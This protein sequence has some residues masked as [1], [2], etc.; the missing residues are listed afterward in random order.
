MYSLFSVPSVAPQNVTVRVNE[1]ML[2]VRWEAP[3]PDK[4]NGILQGYD[5]LVSDGKLDHKVS[6]FA[7]ICIV[8]FLSNTDLKV[9]LL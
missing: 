2:L 3:P 8:F 9:Q 7:S 6:Y 1:S 5:V 4:I